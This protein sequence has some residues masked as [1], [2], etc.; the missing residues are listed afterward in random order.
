MKGKAG[1]VAHLMEPGEAGAFRRVFTEAGEIARFQNALVSWFCSNGR[2]YPWRRTKDPYPILVSEA[3]LQQTQIATVLGRGYFTRWMAA[4]PTWGDLAAA[5]EEEVLKQWEGLGYYNRARNLHKTALIVTREFAGC[6]PEDFE[7]IL[8]LPGIGRYTAGAVMSF[9]FN[10]RAAI[11]DGNVSRVFSR[12]FAITD[13]VDTPTGHR[14]IW[15][16]AESLTPENDAG[17]YNSALMELGQRVCFRASPNCSGCPVRSWC[18]VGQGGVAEEFPVKKGGRVTTVRQERVVIAVKNRRILLCPETGTRRK[19]LWRLPEISSGDA[20]DLI[21]LFRFEYAITRYR[22]TLMVYRHS[23]SLSK[24][25]PEGARWF[26]QEREEEMP[27]IGSP[28]RKA[29]KMFSEIR[30]DQTIND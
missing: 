16:L 25:E 20:A 1:K 27:A 14:V 28:Y 5:T 21:E 10:R 17:L 23:S 9:A 2:D 4:F 8:S 24:A 12:L 11:V 15:G 6:F 29:M 22:V 3:M 13:P 26:N 19:G 18:T 30:D 7:T